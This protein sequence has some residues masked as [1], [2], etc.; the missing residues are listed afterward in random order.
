MKTQC[1]LSVD[2]MAGLTTTLKV[3]MS[4]LRF[5]ESVLMNRRNAV[6][7]CRTTRPTRACSDQLTTYRSRGCLPGAL[8]RCITRRAQSRL[9]LASSTAVTRNA[10]TRVGEHERHAARQRDQFPARHRQAILA[11]T[12][13]RLYRSVDPVIT[14]VQLRF[15]S[16]QCGRG[17][18]GFRTPV[19]AAS[20]R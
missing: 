5:R 18:R 12:S 9:L 6:A 14:A 8:G 20:A 10:R 3:A 17:R 7:R 4:R 15:C 16:V 2:V 19:A 13:S 11:R 1:V